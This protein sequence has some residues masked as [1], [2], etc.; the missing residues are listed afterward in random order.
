MPSDLMPELY[1]CPE[2]ESGHV[3]EFHM[4]NNAANT[5]SCCRYCFQPLPGSPIGGVAPVSINYFEA[6][7]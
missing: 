6:S 4:P 7:D 5:V 2:N 3:Y 1:N